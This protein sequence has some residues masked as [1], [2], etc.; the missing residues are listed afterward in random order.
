MDQ[1]TGISTSVYNARNIG[2]FLVEKKWLG[3]IQ[4]LNKRSFRTEFLTS[5]FTKIGNDKTPFI[6][7]GFNLI[8][9]L[10]CSFLINIYYLDLHKR[11][12]LLT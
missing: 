11:T 5:P 8:W 6:E 9:E 7:Q 3:P 10:L 1:E 2:K 12:I 4:S